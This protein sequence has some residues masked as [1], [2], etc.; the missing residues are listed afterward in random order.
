MIYDYSIYSP[1]FSSPPP[2]T[3]A[4]SSSYTIPHLYDTVPLK[5]T[6]SKFVGFD[7]INNYEKYNSNSEANTDSGKGIGE[8]IR[9]K[10]IPRLIVTSTDIQRTES[11]LL[12]VNTQK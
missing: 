12:I 8:T 10:R 6:L 11:L 2:P 9:T 1:A 7:K 5:K 3:S 4:S